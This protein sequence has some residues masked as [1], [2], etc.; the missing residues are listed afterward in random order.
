MEGLRR[1]PARVGW[2]QPG[3]DRLGLKGKHAE[4]ALVHPPQRLARGHPVKAR[5]AEGVLAQ[6]Q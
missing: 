4:H 1:P 3:V 5:E 2:L 6:R